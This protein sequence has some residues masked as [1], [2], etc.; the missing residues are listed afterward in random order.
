LGVKRTYVTYTIVSY[1]LKKTFAIILI[2]ILFS[3]KEKDN[4]Y[5]EFKESLAYL[6]E[7]SNPDDK[8]SRLT[9]EIFRNIEVVESTSGILNKDDGGNLIRHIVV[10]QKD[11]E[12]WEK[13]ISEKCPKNN[14]IE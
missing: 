2:F 9:D 1:N 13:W 3:C 11:I 14:Q 5:P 12:K 8:K 6:K 4:C 7:F 10:T